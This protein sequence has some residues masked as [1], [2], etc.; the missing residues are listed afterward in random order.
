MRTRL[1][2]ITTA[3]GAALFTASAGPRAGAQSG[4][5]STPTTDVSTTTVS[6]VP[7]ASAA[8]SAPE[9]PATVASPTPAWDAKVVNSDDLPALFQSGAV[10]STVPTT[11]LATPP[12]V[13]A[14]ASSELAVTVPVVA[15]KTPRTTKPVKS[16]Q[17]PPA[18]KTA[19][20]SSSA[21]PTRQDRQVVAV[22]F[23]PPVTKAPTT[24]AKSTNAQAS[25]PPNPPTTK[26]VK[27]TG[28]A[29]TSS[30]VSTA[31]PT[32]APAVKAPSPDGATATT[33]ITTPPAATTPAEGDIWAKLR[34][35]ESGGVYTINTGNGYYGAYQFAPSTW[36]RLGYPG[37]PHE[38]PPAVQ[39]EAA[40]KLQAKAGWGQWP[41][42]SR[43]LG[44]R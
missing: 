4:A 44:L 10:G 29:S 6:A 1:I 40:R 25:N 42:C 41:A 7:T 9:A 34:K 18:P 24:T 2:G 30:P 11:T 28:A 26:A 12:S 8:A 33:L 17:N 16:R 15:K 35:C 13:A 5:A 37:L 31:L 19:D 22:S 38:A 32:A 21:G 27:P 3:L 20:A 43:K 36:R 23:L 14:A 39:D